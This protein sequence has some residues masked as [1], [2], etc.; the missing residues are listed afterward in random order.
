MTETVAEYR[1]TRSRGTDP[2]KV[3]NL[4]G[5]DAELFARAKAQRVALAGCDIADSAII[6]AALLALI[7]KRQET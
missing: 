6:R 7:E 2:L 1:S 4:R 3:V 5:A